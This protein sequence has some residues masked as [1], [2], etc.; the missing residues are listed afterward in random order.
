MYIVQLQSGGFRGLINPNFDCNELE[1]EF[2]EFFYIC[3]N[4]L[5]RGWDFLRFCIPVLIAFSGLF[6]SREFFKL[7]ENIYCYGP[8][9]YRKLVTFC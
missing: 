2:F 5:T 8:T 9:Y 1:S 6:L 4:F 7:S 3:K